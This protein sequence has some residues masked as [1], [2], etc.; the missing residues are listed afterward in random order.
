M[1]LTS[2]VMRS[3]SQLWLSCS[4]CRWTKVSIV[5]DEGKELGMSRAAGQMGGLAAT[6]VHLASGV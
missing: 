4:H 6:R 1:V 3:S 2:L 5:D